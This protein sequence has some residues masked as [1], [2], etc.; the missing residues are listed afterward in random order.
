MMT[1]GLF[2]CEIYGFP[3]FGDMI[4]SWYRCF[5]RPFRINFDLLPQQNLPPVNFVD[6]PFVKITPIIL[7]SDSLYSIGDESRGLV[8]PVMSFYVC[9]CL[10][11]RDYRHCRLN[12]C[13][14]M[15]LFTLIL[16]CWSRSDE[17]VNTRTYYT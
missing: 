7:N 6:F 3:Y 15:D 4:Y 12:G 2:D 8:V 9:L 5:S 17:T 1:F 10:W 11:K 16:K 14:V 13:Y